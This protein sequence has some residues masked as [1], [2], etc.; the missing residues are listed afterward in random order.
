[1]S[2]GC[3]KSFVMICFDFFL[4]TRPVKRSSGVS[5]ILVHIAQDF[6][7]TCI[8]SSCGEKLYV[9][10]MP[11]MGYWEYQ[12]HNEFECLCLLCCSRYLLYHLGKNLLRVKNREWRHC[13][14]FCV[15]ISRC[16]LQCWSIL[17]F[18]VKMIIWMINILGVIR[19][20][21]GVYQ[22]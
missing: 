21:F 1:M 12:Q 6:K 14:L 11:H 22:L 19:I 20:L 13:Q 17:W 5:F 4:Q 7:G 10:A 8:K 18:S 16:K 3:A 9:F 15:C 2:M